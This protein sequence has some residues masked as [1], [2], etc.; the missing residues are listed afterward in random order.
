MA[1]WLCHGRIVSWWESR[2]WRVFSLWL[3]C[4][5]ARHNGFSPPR[6][7]D[8]Y[9]WSL[10]EIP[11]L[12]IHWGPLGTVPLHCGTATSIQTRTTL[13]FCGNALDES[14]DCFFTFLIPPSVEF[15]NRI[16]FD[17]FWP[18]LDHRVASYMYGLSRTFRQ[19][20]LCFSRFYH[21]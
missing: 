8:H 6:R 14:T 16:V 18:F 3:W 19:T 2:W 12:L 17:C 4:L 15:I 20:F 10:F 9:V 7:K 1:D 13:C 5:W 21:L 11:N